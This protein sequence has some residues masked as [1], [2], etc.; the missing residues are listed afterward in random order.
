MVNQRRL[1]GSLRSGSDFVF[2]G[3]GNAASVSASLNAGASVV[4]LNDGTVVNFVGG[5]GGVSV[6]SS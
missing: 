4:R 6:V 3:S 2:V 5:T 1:L